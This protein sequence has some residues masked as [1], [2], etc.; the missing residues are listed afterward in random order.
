MAVWLGMTLLRVRVLLNVVRWPARAREGPN[1][2]PCFALKR[3][4]ERICACVLQSRGLPMPWDFG[5]LDGEHSR[6]CQRWHVVG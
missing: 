1:E 3:H 4:S 2:A 6:R 5:W